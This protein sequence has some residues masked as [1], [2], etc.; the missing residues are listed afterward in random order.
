MHDS[1]DARVVMF[2]I[3]PGQQVAEHTSSSTVLLIVISGSGAVSGATG[4]SDVRTGDVIAYAAGE[5][6]GMRANDET[7]VLAA[8]IAPR[9][10]AH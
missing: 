6:H 9:P 4:S 1:A 5:P 10:G 7:F 8:V 2:R 3:D